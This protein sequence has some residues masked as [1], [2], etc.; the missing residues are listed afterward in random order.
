MISSEMLTVGRKEKVHHD[1][2]HIFVDTKNGV[3]AKFYGH[4]ADEYA[5]LFVRALWHSVH[6][7]E[8][9]SDEAA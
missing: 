6:K 8:A 1:P 2:E 7:D 4:D 3:I 5:E 9:T